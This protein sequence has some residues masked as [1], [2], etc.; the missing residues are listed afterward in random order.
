MREVPFCPILIFFA[1]FILIYLGLIIAIIMTAFVNTFRKN[2][3][4]DELFLDRFE[5][6]TKEYFFLMIRRPPRSTRVRSSAA[7]DVYKR[8]DHP[9]F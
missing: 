2:E 8:Q 6:L 5:R 9:H 1:F 4:I 7:S 3:N